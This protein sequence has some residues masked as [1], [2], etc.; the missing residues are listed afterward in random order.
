MQWHLFAAGQPAFVECPFDLYCLSIRVIESDNCKSGNLATKADSF[1][2][3]GPKNDMARQTTPAR[4]N[5][6]ARHWYQDFIL[7]YFA[8]CD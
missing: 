2:V 6:Q 5:S 8:Q 1:V 3:F 7:D 4:D